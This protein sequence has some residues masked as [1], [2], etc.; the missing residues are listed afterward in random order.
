[1]AAL[2]PADGG[3][4]VET[5]GETLSATNVVVA[6][7]AFQQP[8][9]RVSGVDTAP[10]ELQLT[11]SEYRRPDQLPEGAVLVVGGGQSG[12]QI[13][14]ELLARW[15]LRLPLRRQLRLV[16]APAPR[17]RLGPLGS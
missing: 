12:C 16:P 17:S 1:M 6:S 5:T 3:Y 9:P 4:L 13:S 2:R 8:R 15:S 10:V 7:G 14:D 11:T